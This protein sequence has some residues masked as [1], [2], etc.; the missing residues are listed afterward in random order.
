MPSHDAAARRS[1]RW[2][3]CRSRADGGRGRDEPAGRPVAHGCSIG[4]ASPVDRHRGRARRSRS[5][6]G[7]GVRRGRLGRSGRVVARFDRSERVLRIDPDPDHHDDRRSAGR[8]HPRHGVERRRRERLRRIGNRGDQGQGDPWW[9]A[10]RTRHLDL[11][12]QPR[13]RSTDRDGSCRPRSVGEFTVAVPASQRS[14]RDERRNFRCVGWVVHVAVHRRAAQR[15]VDVRT[16]GG[17][18]GHAGRRCDRSDRRLRHLLR[19]QGRLVRTV[20]TPRAAGL[21]ARP[22]RTG[23]RGRARAAGCCPRHPVQALDGRNA[24]AGGAVGRPPHSCG[25]RWPV[26]SSG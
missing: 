19:G 5:G 17:A 14:V 7:V 8:R 3:P 18:M 22:A 21:L 13:S 26:L 11:R 20:A 25:A 10:D 16:A 9:R 15:R 23:D 6:C 24:Q 4:T 12:V 1:L 2:P